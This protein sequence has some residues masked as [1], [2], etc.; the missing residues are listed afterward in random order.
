MAPET[1]WTTKVSDNIITKTVK[2]RIS[3]I[4][5]H[6]DAIENDFINENDNKDD[7]DNVSASI[8]GY[9]EN[10]DRIA[11]LE[12]DMDERYGTCLCTG[13]RQRRA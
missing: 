12:A 11:Q 4:D 6:M 5:N 7:P 2:D 8:A 13:L 1:D 10:K 3:Q 9:C